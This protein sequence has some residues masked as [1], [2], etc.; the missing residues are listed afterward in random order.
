M[1][2]TTWAVRFN[3]GA[4]LFCGL[5]REISHRHDVLAGLRTKVPKFIDPTACL[6]THDFVS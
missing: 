5:I 4:E 2:S 1:V 3:K 6:I